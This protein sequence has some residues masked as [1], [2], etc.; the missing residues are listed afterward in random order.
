VLV[1]IM[2]ANYETSTMQPIGEIARITREGV[3]LRVDEAG[4]SR[5]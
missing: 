5:E 2:H 1:A 4:P 3:L